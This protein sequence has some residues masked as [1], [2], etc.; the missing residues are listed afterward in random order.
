MK[1]KK[2]FLFENHQLDNEHEQHEKDNIE[3]DYYDCY[4]LKRMF[5]KE[6]KNP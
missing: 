6:K 4:F 2:F 5:K 3:I 1:K